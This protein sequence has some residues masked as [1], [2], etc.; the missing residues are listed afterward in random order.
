MAHLGPGI[1]LFWCGE[2]IWISFVTCGLFWDDAICR[3]YATWRI[4]PL[5]KWLGS[6]PFIS[7]GKAI[8]EGEQPY[9]GDLLTMVNNNLQSGMIL[10]VIPKD[11]DP[12]L[13]RRID[14][15]KIP[16]PG[17]RIG[18]GKSWIL[19][20]YKRILRDDKN[21]THRIHGTG[22]MYLHD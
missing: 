6:P 17:H 16:S 9:L 19:R 3:W 4:I 10:Q 22:T 13:N 11:P 15:R 20:T 18:S 14:G 2:W 8:L 5:S 12:S 1:V 21:I 7:H